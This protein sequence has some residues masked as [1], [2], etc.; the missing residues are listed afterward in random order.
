MKHRISFDWSDNNRIPYRAVIFVLTRIGLVLGWR[1]L[2][3]SGFASIAIVV[4]GRLTSSTLTASEAVWVL[5]GMEE[6]VVLSDNTSV[7]L[8]LI[9]DVEVSMRGVAGLELMLISDVEVS[10]REVVGLELISDVE[11]S[12]GGVGIVF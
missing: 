2:M 11:V 10:V 7:T 3:V 9:S 4:L 12:T 5:D 8:E 1:F 6:G